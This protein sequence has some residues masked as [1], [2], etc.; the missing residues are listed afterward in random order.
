MHNYQADK[1]SGILRAI[2]DRVDNNL[3]WEQCL[4]ALNP[5]KKQAKNAQKKFFSTYKTKDWLKSKNAA[6]RL[7]MRGSLRLSFKS[8]LGQLTAA[9]SL[10]TMTLLVILAMLVAQ[11]NNILAFVYAGKGPS[12]FILFQYPVLR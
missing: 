6:G 4:E 2:K 12:C 5:R 7:S 3:S 8:G 9:L 11:K 1:Y 10:V